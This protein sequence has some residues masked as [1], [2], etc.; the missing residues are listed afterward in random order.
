MALSES[1]LSSQVREQVQIPDEMSFETAAAMGLVYQTAHFALVERGGVKP[2]DYVLV[3]GAAGGVGLAGVR[4]RKDLGPRCWQASETS[5]K[6]NSLG[7]RAF[8]R[9]LTCELL[10]CVRVC[11]SK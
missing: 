2:G 10:S 1:R 6:L 4:S 3:G 11:D 9:S 7:T 8:M 5:R